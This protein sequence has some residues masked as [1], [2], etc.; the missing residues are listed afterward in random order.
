MCTDSDTELDV[1]LIQNNAHIGAQVAVEVARLEREER[2][3]HASYTKYYPSAGRATPPAPALAAL[4]SSSPAATFSTTP[5]L[6]QSLPPPSVLVFGSAAMDLTSSS[7]PLSPRS[8]TPGI[9]FISPGGVGRNIAEAAQNLLPTGSVLLISAIGSQSRSLGACEPDG[10]GKL[11][12]TEMERSGLR[13][14]GLFCG[15]DEDVSTAACCLTLD[16]DGDLVNGVADMGIVETITGETVC[17]SP[18]CHSQ[19]LT[20]SRLV[21]RSVDIIQRW[22]Y[23]IATFLPKRWRAS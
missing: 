5:S 23:S 2:N 19:K 15:P 9:I 3:S 20:V 4:S 17:F 7:H 1:K 8:T 14:D 11:L 6:T 18:G 13:T 21:K 22:S 16:K 12:R 10:F